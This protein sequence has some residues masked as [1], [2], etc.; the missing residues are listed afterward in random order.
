MTSRRHHRRPSSGLDQRRGRRPRSGLDLGGSRGGRGRRV[1]HRSPACRWSPSACSAS[2]RLGLTRSAPAAAASISL[3]DGDVDRHGPAALVNQ[4]DQA[5]VGARDD[6]RRNAAAD[7]HHLSVTDRLGDRGQHVVPF[8]DA[9]LGP[10]LVDH[11]GAAAGLDDHRGAAQ[12]ATDR[13]GDD[14]AAPRRA[15]SRRPP[16]RGGRETGRRA[17][18]GPS[19]VR[20]ARHT[21]TA[22]PPGVTAAVTARSTSPGASAGSWSVRSIVWLS[23]TTNMTPDSP[24]RPRCP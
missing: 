21:L 23:P 20:A 24:F 22:L 1:R 4:L 15:A 12:L 3:V 14:V 17:A 18:P 6:A 11:G 8:G 13:H 9:E 10:R 7:R 16:G 5:A 2:A 19:R